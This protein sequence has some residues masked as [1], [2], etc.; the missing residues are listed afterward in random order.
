MAV[1]AGRWREGVAAAG[2]ALASAAFVLWL[3]AERQEHVA[4]ADVLVKL[5]ACESDLGARSPTVTAELVKQIDLVRSEHVARQ[6]FG[7][8][9][10]NADEATG[11]AAMPFAPWVPAPRDERLRIGLWE[12]RCLLTLSYVDA[13]PRQAAGMANAYANAYVRVYESLAA[14]HVAESAVAGASGEGSSTALTDAEAIVL[15]REVAAYATLARDGAAASSTRAARL[16]RLQAAL[17]LHAS[18]QILLGSDRNSLPLAVVLYQPAMPPTTAASDARWR[19]GVVLV[20]VFAL[21]LAVPLWR[22]FRVPLLRTD[23]DITSVLGQ[24][25]LGRVPLNAGVQGV[26]MSAPPSLTYVSGDV[27]DSD[28]ILGRSLGSL[29]RERCGL[30]DAQIDEIRHHQSTHG[31]LFGESAKALGLVQAKDLSAALADQR[32]SDPA[33]RSASVASDG[34]VLTNDAREA[35]Q[36]VFRDIHAKLLQAADRGGASADDGRAIAVISPQAGDGRSFVA[37]NLAVAASQ[38]GLRT[39]LVDADLHQPNQHEVFGLPPGRGLAGL[40][41][42]HLDHDLLRYVPGVPGLRLLPAGT[43]VRD[44]MTLLRRSVFREFLRT[45]AQRYDV[46]FVDTPPGLDGSVAIEVARHCNAAIAVGRRNKTSIAA[47]K[48][49]LR[50]SGHCRVA[51]VVMNAA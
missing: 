20:V 17:R 4:Q 26:R 27:N 28:E 1:L 36:R 35:T 40:L 13:D 8:V 33:T 31:T 42:G 24:H 19:A 44:G 22:E 9:R 3:G 47:M 48:D 49:L 38:L 37:A 14:R 16:V 25:L 21:G 2:L 18:R 23:S 11:R 32:G 6:V 12:E 46:V 45:A 30:D 41:R 7:V 15:G 43:A 5:A 34:G 39:L 50:L 10:S 51:G 29:L